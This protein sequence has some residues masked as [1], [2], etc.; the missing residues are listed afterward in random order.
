MTSFLETSVIV[1][2][3]TADDPDKIDRCEALFRN[4]KSGKT[5][6]CVT[7]LTVAEAIWVLLKVYRFPKEAVANGMRRLLN[8]PHLLCED[9]PLILAALELF[10]STPLS[11][12]DA[13]HAVVLP[14]R[15]IT[16]LYSY[17]TDFD[18]VPELKRRE[19]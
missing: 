17:D 18:L 5:T 12:V 7:H 16:E 14:A 8:T 6:L 3:L 13:Y 15:G 19:P 11:F 9:A 1:R 2:Y 4:T 10:Q